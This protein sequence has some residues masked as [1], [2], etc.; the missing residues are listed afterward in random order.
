[1]H[2]RETLSLTVML[3]NEQGIKTPKPWCDGREGREKVIPRHQYD[4]NSE[5]IDVSI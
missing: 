4:P 5:V 3:P 1:M 2:P